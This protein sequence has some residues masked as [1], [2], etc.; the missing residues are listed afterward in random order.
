[1]PLHI[2]DTGSQ[3]ISGNFTTIGNLS[4]TGI[5]YGDGSGLTNV[6][7]GGGGVSFVTL[8]PSAYATLVSIGSADAGTIYIVQE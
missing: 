1:M 7:G 5:L 3:T 2:T 8:T 6:A 4:A